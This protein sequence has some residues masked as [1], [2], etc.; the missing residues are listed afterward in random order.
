MQRLRFFPDFGG[1]DPL[2]NARGVGI[3]LDAIPVRQETKTA[4]RDW[5]QRWEVVARHKMDAE[6]FAAGMTDRT[7]APVPERS[8]KAIGD[9]GRCLCAQVQHELGD[10]WQVDYEG[11]R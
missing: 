3:S 2:W 11:P 10:E 5:C 1:A 9:E 4:L 6:D 8:W 7:A